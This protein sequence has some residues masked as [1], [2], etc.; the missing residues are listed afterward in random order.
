MASARDTLARSLALGLVADLLLAVG[1]MMMKIRADGLPMARGRGTFSAVMAWVR[2]PVWIGGL[3]VQTAGYA[4]YMVALAGAPVSMMAVAMQGGIALFVVLAVVLLGERARIWEWLGIG[5]FMVAALMLVGSLDAGAV[6]SSVDT[7]ALAISSVVASAITLALLVV[8]ALRE[9]GATTAIASGIALG[10]A[11]LYTKPL[12]DRLASSPD[13]AA[14]AA[15]LLTS[16]YTYLTIMTNVAGLVMLQ[17]SFAM[18]RGIIAMP[19]SSAISNVIP[20]V[21][22]IAVFGERLPGNPL[23]AAMRASAFVL[24]IAASAALA[25]GDL[26]ASASR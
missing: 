17:N 13:L 18:G 25:A 15:V 1:L 2:D 22:G 9:K 6:Q 5:T 7:G 16:P 26:G 11:A 14:F 3:A 4:L 12:A 19:L 10:F 23:A 24:T 20:I 8:P 21:G